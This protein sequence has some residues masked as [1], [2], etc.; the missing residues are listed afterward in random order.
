MRKT[1]HARP[2]VSDSPLCCY[3][4]VLLFAHLDIDSWQGEQ[5]K[6]P[7]EDVR[8]EEITFWCSEMNCYGEEAHFLE[9]LRVEKMQVIRGGWGNRMS[10][11]L[12]K[13]LSKQNN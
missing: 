11:I 5:P 9:N 6:P 8:R 10:G 3:C 2:V 1:C 12:I 13:E 4:T 7:S